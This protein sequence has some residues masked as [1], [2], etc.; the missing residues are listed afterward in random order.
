LYKGY[1]KSIKKVVFTVR[2]KQVEMYSLFWTEH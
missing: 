2:L 1:N